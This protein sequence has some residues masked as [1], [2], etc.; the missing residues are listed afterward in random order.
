LLFESEISS[1]DESE[2]TELEYVGVEA[3]L[4]LSFALE[5]KGGSSVEL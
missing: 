4:E 1:G 2:A 3:L 5:S